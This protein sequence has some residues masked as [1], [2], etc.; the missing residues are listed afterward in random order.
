MLGKGELV[1]LPPGPARR[2]PRGLLLKGDHLRR[3][4]PW[5]RLLN[6]VASTSDTVIG[7]IIGLWLVGAALCSG[8]LFVR[9]LLTHGVT[10]GPW[11]LSEEEKEHRRE[12]RS[13]NKEVRSIQR[14]HESRLRS[15]SDE[16]KRAEKQ[17]TKGVRSL[18]K[19]LE[20]AQHPAKL[21]GIWSTKSWA[22]LYEDRLETSKGK[23][24]LTPGLVAEVSSSGNLAIGG[25]STLTRMGTGAVI[26]GPLGFMVGMAAKKDRKVDMRELY[27]IVQNEAGGVVLPCS[28]DAGEKVRQF[29]LNIQTAARNAPAAAQRRTQLIADAKAA[30]ATASRDTAAI[31]ARRQEYESIAADRPQLP[32]PLPARTLSSS[33]DGEIRA[34]G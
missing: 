33:Q 11:R 30:L 4:Q 22:K 9:W 12:L 2:R 32:A 3:P 10:F 16:L 24:R 8:F 23:Y 15:A 28:P 18:E 7:L 20:K 5:R 26:A 13:Y 25:R 19:Q 1:D 6:V 27:L 29:A 31:D 14:V 34:S 17:Y 21:D